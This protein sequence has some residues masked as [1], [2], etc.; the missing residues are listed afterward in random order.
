MRDLR[1]ILTLLT[2][3]RHRVAVFSK[4]LCSAPR[5]QVRARIMRSLCVAA[6]QTVVFRVC[7]KSPN[8]K[9]SHQKRGA[10]YFLLNSHNSI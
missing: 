5:V 3:P 7:S 4:Y 1:L 10:K 9:P 2:F 6:K 8:P